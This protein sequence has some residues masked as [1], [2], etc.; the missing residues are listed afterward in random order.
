M[1]RKILNR[2]QIKS[3]MRQKS[4]NHYEGKEYLI[5]SSKETSKLD[6]MVGSGN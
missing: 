4:Q 2:E 6:G 3:K 1:I 5:K